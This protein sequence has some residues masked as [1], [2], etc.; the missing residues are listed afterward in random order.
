MLSV[1][2]MEEVS[3]QGKSGHQDKGLCGGGPLSQDWI[4]GIGAE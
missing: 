2:W 1:R 3:D 4:P